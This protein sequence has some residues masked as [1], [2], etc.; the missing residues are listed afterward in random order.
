M[1]K[2]KIVDSNKILCELQEQLLGLPADDRVG[3]KPILQKMFLAFQELFINK[4]LSYCHKHNFKMSDE[5]ITDMATDMAM[6]AIAYYKRNPNKKIDY[7]VTYFHLYA[8]IAVLYKKSD[9]V[10]DKCLQ[11][12][13]VED[14]YAN[15]DIIEKMFA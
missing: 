3:R 13:S 10:I 15:P 6:K 5:R 1:Q 12:Y 11:N 9:D 14:F 4:L 8:F 2:R 7:P